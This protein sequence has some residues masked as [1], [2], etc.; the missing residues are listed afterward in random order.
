MTGAGDQ[1]Q[2]R[3]R[4]RR[5]RPRAQ[6]PRHGDGRGRPDGPG[7]VAVSRRGGRRASRSTTRHLVRRAMRAAFDAMGVRLPGAPA[8][9]HQRHPAR[10]R[11]RLVVGGDRRRAVLRPAASWTAGRRLH[12]RRRRSSSSP[13]RSRGTPTTSRRRS[14][15]ASPWPTRPG[16][17]FR[18]TTRRWT[19]AVSAVVLRARR[20]GRR[21]RSP[22][23]CCRERCRTR[24]AAAQRR[25]R[26]AAGR[27]AEPAP[28]AC[29][30]TRPRTACTSD[31]REPA[32]PESLALV[33]D[34]AGRRPRGVSSRAPGPPSWS[35]DR[36]RSTEAAVAARAPA[37]WAVHTLAV[38]TE[39]ARVEA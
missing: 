25:P 26:G 14:T 1:R 27:R 19:R 20:P 4:L 9:V 11:P 35:L 10:P 2:P 34:A 6:P 22:A 24:D 30:S 17:R 18:A 38:G 21:R 28:R 33:R 15:A 8:A 36:R 5:A 3:P 7:E 16:G 31:Y 29:C 39:G 12:G 37:G 23:G 13:P 32:M